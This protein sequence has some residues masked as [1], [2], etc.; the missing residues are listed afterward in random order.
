[1]SFRK[2]RILYNRRSGPGRSRFEAVQQAVGRSW[3]VTADRAWYFPASPTESDAMVDAAVA[4][5]ADC[6]LVCG[7]DGTV[8]SVGRRLLGTGVAMGVV[9]L[10]SGNG[11][12]RHFGLPLD[13]EDC[14]AALAAGG[15]RSMDVGVAGGVPFL[16]SASVAWDAA[17]VEAY[18]A[19]PFRGVASY[20]LAGV[21]S[22]F[23]Y[24]PQPLETVVDGGET[25]RL[26]K[27]FLFT[28]G[29][30]AGWGGGA[31]IDADASAED[32]RLE[33]IAGERRDAPKM[34]AVVFRVFSKGGKALPRVLHRSFRSL[35]VSRPS[36]APVQLDGE[37]VDLPASFDV[38]V[39]PAA[40]RILVPALPAPPVPTGG[41]ATPS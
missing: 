34:L 37:I 25:I 13:P 26:E 7:G 20:A 10:G 4:D 36:A 8:S 41:N 12:A 29:N 21:W 14:L 28:V 40:L 27:P 1:M 2:I 24:K 19:I 9:P 16:V 15:V 22:Y 6:L 32:G 18:N 23:D 30:L 35:S 3:G 39:R 5:G 38:T 17:L 33:L 11:L 31:L